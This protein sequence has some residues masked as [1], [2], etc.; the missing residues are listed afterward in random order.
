[1]QVWRESVCKANTGCSPPTNKMESCRNPL[2]YL[3]IITVSFKKIR[4]EI[5]FEM[6]GYALKRDAPEVKACDHYHER[7][8]K[9]YM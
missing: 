2:L 7:I 8:M 9:G 1:M 6:S 4:L 5:V 3:F